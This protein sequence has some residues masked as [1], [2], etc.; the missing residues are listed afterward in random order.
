MAGLATESW[1]VQRTKPRRGGG[2][3]LFLMCD[4]EA[5]QIIPTHRPFVAICYR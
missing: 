2:N 4:L 3:Q 5:T 1:D